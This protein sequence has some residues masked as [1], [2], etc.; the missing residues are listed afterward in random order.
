MRP[1]IYTVIIGAYEPL[2]PPHVIDLKADYVCLCD[3][4]MPEVPPW[5]IRVVECGGLG[6]QKESR[7]FKILSHWWFPEAE[8][9][10]YCDGNVRP[11]TTFPFDW[12]S[13]HDIAACPH[14]DTDNAYEEAVRCLR[15]NK[16]DPELIKAQIARYQ[17]E[18]FPEHAGAV[19]CSV[20]LR[21]HTDAVARFNQAWW[22][23]I[24]RGS[25]RDQV[26]FNY[27]SWKLDIAYDEIPWGGIWDNDCFEYTDPRWHRAPLEVIRLE[28]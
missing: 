2:L 27:V 12:L 17:A 15:W 18:G 6:A 3:V 20:I 9:T 11:K 1:V 8:Y 19:G 4:P 14:P 21:R 23:E 10:L 24:Q 26:S 5:E 28:E 22:E 13:E 7:R 25:A 16:G